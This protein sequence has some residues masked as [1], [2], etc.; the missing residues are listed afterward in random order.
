LKGDVLEQ[1]LGYWTKTLADAPV[2]HSLPLDFERP[3][4]QTFDGEVLHSN[5]D[6]ATSDALN[7]FCQAQGATLF[8]GLHAAFSILLARYGNETDILIGS[9]IANREQAEVAG[10]IGFFANTLVLRN[11]LSGAPD[12]IGVVAQSKRILLDAY[13]HQQLPFEQIVEHLQVARSLRHSPLFQIMLV[14]QNNEQGTLEMP[15]LTLGP[16]HQQATIAMFDLTL[17][18]NPGEQGLMLSWEYNTALFAPASM[19]RLA[20]HFAALL[21]GLLAKP[22]ENVFRCNFLSET[23][24]RQLL[25]G[26]N[27]NLHPFTPNLCMHELFEAQVARQPDAIAL[28]FETPA[29]PQQISYADLNCQANRLAHYLVNQRGVQADSLVGLCFERSPH[30]VIAI[31][32]ILKAGGA[33]VPLDPHYPASRLRHM[34]H[35]SALQTVL[36]LSGLWENTPVSAE[37]ALCLDD[38]A[39][40]AA[41]MQQAPHDIVPRAAGPSALAY[42]IYTSGSTGN[43]KGVMITHANLVNMVQGVQLAY[44]LC[45]NDCYLQ[46]ASINF[47]MSVEDI[48]A[49]LGSGA[50][51]VLRTDAWLQSPAYFWQ[52]CADFGVTILNLPTAWWHQLANDPDSQPAAP[53]RHITIGG[54]QVSAVAIRNWM[55]KDAPLPRLF[56]AYGPTECTVGASLTP[57]LD[58]T[59]D[60]GQPLPNYLLCVLDANGLPSPT[61]VAGELYIGGAGVARGYLN[62]PELTREKFID[63]PF[64]QLRHVSDRLYKSGDLVRWLDDGTLQYLGRVDN[65]VKLRGFRIELSEIENAL[66]ALAPVKEALVLAQDGAAGDKRLVAWVVLK[67]AMPESQDALVAALMAELAQK[68][69]EFML[70]GALLVLAQWPLT[71]NGKVD[72]QALPKANTPLNKRYLAPR[73]ALEQSLCQ[74]FQSVLDV[75]EVGIDD[76]FFTLGGHSLLGLRLVAEVSRVLG[77]AVPLRTLFAA[78]TVSALAALGQQVDAGTPQLANLVPIRPAATAATLPPLFLIHPGEGEV[79]YAQQLARWLD[80]QWPLYALAASGFE[81]GEQ[82]LQSVPAMAELYIR[83]MRQVQPQGPYRVAGWSAGGTIAIEIARQL[84]A[85]GQTLAFLGLIDTVDDYGPGPGATPDQADAGIAPPQPDSAWSDAQFL[86]DELADKLDPGTLATLQPLARAGEVDAMLDQCRQLG[87]FAVTLELASLRRHLAVRA[88]IHRA[89][90][91]YALPALPALDVPVTLICARD[92]ASDQIEAAWR[93]RLGERLFATVVDGDHYSIMDEPNIQGLASVLS[94]RLVASQ[95]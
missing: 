83:G 34:L 87:L 70:P 30:M 2:V 51:L 63:N 42:V 18:V 73:N 89:L 41:L 28:R 90:L 74:I 11:D 67:E 92:H 72:Y 46:F 8:M 31:L 10:L 57:I 71:A 6:R 68:L 82:P 1:Q 43:P 23:Q 4:V 26:R 35:D 47:D 48:F 27:L 15:G 33:Y 7:A 85:A 66:T 61:G 59:N 62:Q 3:P 19:E 21:Q 95:H 65:Q 29:G 16:V 44:G 88:G 45:A 58:S 25:L 37:Q 32:A 75:P 39:I 84:Q 49:S 17:T 55:Q 52:C 91:H 86:L 13:A 77:V 53:V 80:P 79:A 12:F 60:I 78:P 56:N 40:Q 81:A 36:T 24:T 76:N 5:I 50:S 64:P 14:L 22:H 9:P 54:E 38:A 93:A 20:Q 94:Q 69:P